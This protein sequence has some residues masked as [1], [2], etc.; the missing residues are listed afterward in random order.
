MRKALCI[1][2]DFYENYND[3]NGC[4]NDARLVSDSLKTNHNGSANF[5]VKSLYSSENESI[6][7]KYMFES[8]RELFCSYCEDCD[9]VLF[10]FS[11]HGYF[12]GND[13]YLC[14]SDTNVNN[15]ASAIPFNGVL[16]IVNESKAKNKIIILDCCFSGAMG[17]SKD[18]N[19]SYSKISDGTIILT[20]SSKEQVSIECDGKG[21][22]T[23]LFVEALDG[24]SMNILGEVSPG[25]I[26]AYI[27]KALGP[28]EQRPI[29]KANVRN[30]IS[31]KKNKPLIELEELKKIVTIFESKNKI[32]QLDPSYEP[33]KSNLQ[34]KT[35]NKD[36]ENIFKILQ[37]YTRL[38]LVIP[39][40]AEHMYYAAI[41]SKHCKLTEL[42]KSYWTLIKKERI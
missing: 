10:Y 42:G 19:F 16:D 36:N 20:A 26:Y 21:L 13:A 28:W 25:S 35:V 3:L 41:N 22:F 5:N 27:D 9:V 6:S 4:I 7:S 12:D 33:D 24:A 39:E 14:A 1:G 17:Y 31:L 40:G 2:I 38:G 8:I 23:S 15:I 18:D 37:N 29:F 11:G 30:F 32:Y 34:D